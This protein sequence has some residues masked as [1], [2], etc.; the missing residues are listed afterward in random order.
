MT[1]DFD[2][3]HAAPE[4]LGACDPCAMGKKDRHLGGTGKTRHTLD[5]VSMLVR[6]K[7]R[8]QI[9]VAQATRFKPLAHVF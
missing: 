6:D 7:D 9:R 8:A 2:T 1:V 3:L 5:M 4:S